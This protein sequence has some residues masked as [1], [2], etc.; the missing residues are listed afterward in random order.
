MDQIWG[1]KD[2][3]GGM[4]DQKWDIKDNRSIQKWDTK[5]R[6]LIMG[7]SRLDQ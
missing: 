6:S 1:I 7:A 5:H 2:I 3:D 4:A